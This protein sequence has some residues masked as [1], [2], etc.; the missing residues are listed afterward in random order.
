MYVDD[1][2]EMGSHDEHPKIH[3][4]IKL[5]H[6]V[7]NNSPPPGPKNGACSCELTARR[8]GKF[9][10][11]AGWL[12]KRKI[13]PGKLVV[14]GSSTLNPLSLIPFPK[15]INQTVCPPSTKRS[16][17]EIGNNVRFLVAESPSHK[18]MNP[19][20]TAVAELLL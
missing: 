5:I 17:E 13:L 12:R 20:A 11:S 3:S 15:F 10:L 1:V 2:V 4:R 6:S 14:G 19:E 7:T 16:T 18:N 8:N 9:V